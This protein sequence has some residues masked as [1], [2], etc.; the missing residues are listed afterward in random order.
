MKL[1]LKNLVVFST[2]LLCY[3]GFSFIANKF[4][5][6]QEKVINKPYSIL[7]NGDSHTGVGINPQKFKSAINIAQGGDNMIMSYWKLKFLLN[8]SRFDTLIFSFS[9][10][11]ISKVQESKFNNSSM[12]PEIM[13]RSILIQDFASLERL[14]LD[15]N[16]KT[17]YKA[18]FRQLFLYPNLNQY[19]FVGE[20]SPSD[21]SNLLP[22]SDYRIKSHFYENNK[23]VDKSKIMTNYMDSI[24]YLCRK[25]EVFPVI[26]S[27]P[28][29]KS[30]SD[31]VPMVIK[32]AY[33]EEKD[34]IINKNVLF[35]D[36]SKES[37]SNHLFYDCDHLN[38]KGA[39]KFT[40]LLIETLK[41][42]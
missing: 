2:V 35:L 32:K 12:T 36:F 37:F 11:N 30:Y 39:N 25:K 17:Y 38:I 9:Y 40:D 26:I 3:F 21:Y 24:I 10:N 6:S 27:P 19:T 28:L 16:Y 1:F 23:L 31:N 33:A 41:S 14:N 22:S 29:H 42:K 13:K 8:E 4:F 20:F 7:I 15:I 18:Y 5:L 34:R